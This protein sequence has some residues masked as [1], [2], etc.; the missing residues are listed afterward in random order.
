MRMC[1]QCE[2]NL[3]LDIYRDLERGHHQQLHSLHHNRLSKE[4]EIYLPMVVKKIM[5]MNLG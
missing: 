3:C 5:D 2:L 4:H 1:W